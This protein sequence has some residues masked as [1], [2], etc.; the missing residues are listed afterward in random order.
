MTL[1]VKP[2]ED[3]SNNNGLVDNAH[4]DESNVNIYHNDEEEEEEKES[5]IG[6]SRMD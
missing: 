1:I 3:G 6:N 5:N 2:D 4:K